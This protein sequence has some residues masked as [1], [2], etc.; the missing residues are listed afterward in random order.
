M[1]G[2]GSAVF[3]PLPPAFAAQDLLQK[4]PPGW[5]AKTV[6]NLQQHPH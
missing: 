6:F 4:L 2:S 5:I 1:T 3:A